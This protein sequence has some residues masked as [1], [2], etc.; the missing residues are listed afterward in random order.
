MSREPRAGIAAAIL[1]AMKW[2][3]LTLTAAIGCGGSKQVNDPAAQAREAERKR[4]EAM[5]PASPYEIRSVRGYQAP[6]TCGQGP[7]RIDVAAV[8]ARFGEQLEINIC[9]PRSLQGDYRLTR[10]TGTS[11]P[12]HFG[13]RNNSE[14]CLATAA[15]AAQRGGAST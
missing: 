15:E 13:S 7:Y 1:S 10:G 4:I 6:D 8:G 11:E 5:R 12:R 14:H 2:W 9:A 3:V